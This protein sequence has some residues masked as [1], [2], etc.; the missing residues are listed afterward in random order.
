MPLQ[1]PPF[2]STFQFYHLVG[3]WPLPTRKSTMPASVVLSTTTPE[4]DLPKLPPPSTP[5]KRKW[6]ETTLGGIQACTCTKCPAC[7]VKNVVFEQVHYRTT[8][9]TKPKPI[10]TSA[11]STE[12][13]K[14]QTLATSTETTKRQT[15]ATSTETTNEAR[16]A[17]RK[18]EAPKFKM[19]KSLRTKTWRTYQGFTSRKLVAALSQLEGL[20]RKKVGLFV[21]ATDSELPAKKGFR[22]DFVKH[23]RR[24]GRGVYLT[25]PTPRNLAY[26]RRYGE[27]LVL[28]LVVWQASPDYLDDH[29]PQWLPSTDELVLN[30]SIADFHGA[31]FTTKP[32]SVFLEVVVPNAAQV[33]PLNIMPSDIPAGVVANVCIAWRQLLEPLNVGRWNLPYEI[34]RTHLFAHQRNQRTKQAELQHSNA[35][36]S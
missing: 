13:T 17:A 7:Q 26:A 30:E 6:W 18:S 9:T 35:P 4:T 2:F 34:G 23:A 16:A 28:C 11:T 1:T 25:L 33:I 10:P 15:L 12:T 21:H 22:L 24:Y 8:T 32:G 29:K 36:T 14:R 3:D 20:S 31:L 19:A 27:K 5:K